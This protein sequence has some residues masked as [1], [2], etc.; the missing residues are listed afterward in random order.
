MTLLLSAML[1]AV[2][3]APSDSVPVES[4]GISTP[5][6]PLGN[7]GTWVTTDDYPSMSLR[8][9]EEGTARFRVHIGRDGRVKRCEITESSGSSLLDEQTCAALTF[10]ARFAP[11]RDAQG[12][13]AIGSYSNTVRWEIPDDSPEE[14]AAARVA[15]RPFNSTIRYY[16]DFGEDGTV[17]NCQ[18]VEFTAE[19]PLGII[20]EEIFCAQYLYQ[21]Y[22]IEPYTDENGRPVA[23]RARISIRSVVEEIPGGSDTE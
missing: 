12:N 15:N 20:P 6:V 3:Y 14:A 13:P 10:R 7:P 5:A 22:S 4:G 21:G 19:T 23:R 16:L 2:S 11:A 8:L 18:M 17:T 1:L 9:E